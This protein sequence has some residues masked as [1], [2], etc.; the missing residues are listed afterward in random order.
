MLQPMS[1]YFL[2]FRSG[3]NL[4][5][6]WG[7]KIRLHKTSAFWMCQFFLFFTSFLS[8]LKSWTESTN[9]RNSG[10]AAA[11]PWCKIPLEQTASTSRQPSAGKMR[12]VARGFFRLPQ[13]KVWHETLCWKLDFMVNGVDWHAIKLSEEKANNF[14]LENIGNQVL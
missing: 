9:L 10:P 8:N 5:C 2:S 14:F 13:A 3:S 4:W 7:V 11:V 12:V 1:V 6:K